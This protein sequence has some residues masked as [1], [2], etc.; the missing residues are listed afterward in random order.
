MSPD[1]N[2][3]LAE[4]K[5]ELTSLLGNNLISLV[6]FGSRARGDYDDDSDI[7]IAVILK[8]LPRKLKNQILDKVAEIELKHLT[9]V[10]VVT[11]SREE[12]SQLKKRERR[13]AIDIETE[14]I[15]L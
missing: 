8:D 4:L 2:K 10:S 14:G 5:Y 1:E 6:L 12:F 7:D 3:A 11:F 15:P 13:I 9:P